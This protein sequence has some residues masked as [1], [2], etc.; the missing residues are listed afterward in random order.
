LRRFF[1]WDSNSM[2]SCRNRSASPTSDFLIRNFEKESH[3]D[4]SFDIVCLNVINVETFHTS[5][6]WWERKQGIL[7]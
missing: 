1:A 4:K 3:V 2:I 5:L 7:G 6:C